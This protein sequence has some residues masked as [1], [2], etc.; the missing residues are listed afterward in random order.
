MVS[1]YK[2]NEDFIKAI[3]N[4]GYADSCEDSTIVESL[5]KEFK[6]S[7]ATGYRWL[8]TSKIERDRPD[9]FI[10]RELIEEFKLNAI[11]YSN[12]TLNELKHTHSNNPVEVLEAIDKVASIVCK[13]K[14]A[15]K[16]ANSRR[17]ETFFLERH[18]AEFVN[19]QVNPSS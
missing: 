7:Q 10:S 5:M 3:I 11:E 9:A 18:G 8:R 19:F 14:K 6:I 16:F 12:K 4:E 13:L 17:A 1:K 2:S 15:T